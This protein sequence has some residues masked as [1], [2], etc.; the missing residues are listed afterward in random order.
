MSAIFWSRPG[1]SGGGPV[2]RGGHTANMMGNLLV[3]FGGTCSDE[4]GFV[5]FNDVWVLDTDVSPMNW[6]KPQ[7]AASASAPVGRYSHASCTIGDKL[8]V[9]GGRGAGGKVLA[10][11]WELDVTHWSWRAVISSTAP[12]PPRFAHSLT[13]VGGQLLVFGGWDGRVANDDVWFFN[14][15]KGTWSRPKVTGTPPCA[16]AGHSSAL[17]ARAG[18]LLVFGGASY[19]EQRVPTYLRDTVELDLVAMHWARPRVTGDYPAARA[20]AATA[21]LANVLV[22]F[23]GWAGPAPLPAPALP[24]DT[25]ASRF[26][27]AHHAGLGFGSTA[28]PGA[29]VDVPYGPHAGTSLLDLDSGEWVAPH[30]AGDGP[31][32]RYGSSASARGL[33]LFMMGGWEGGRSL[34]ELLVLDLSALAGE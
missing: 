33:R 16:R 26:Q 14:G 4:S 17:D 27:L 15:K 9:Y 20:G 10:D 19:D 25:A 29:T 11:L 1:T 5:Y 21:T 3:V 6:S 7:M 32:Y 22:L 8:F 34:N 30:V 13:A 24:A 23:G 28:P 2:A 12:P 18:R 31:G